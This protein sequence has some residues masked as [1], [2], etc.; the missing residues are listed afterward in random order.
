MLLLAQSAALK[1][2]EKDMATA[3]TIPLPWYD[4][5]LEL[6]SAPE[7]RLRMQ[8]LSDRVVLSRTRVS[9]LVDEMVAAGYVRREP[10]PSDGRAAFAVITDEG[11]AARRATA[12]LYL[13][14]IDRHFSRHLS[15]AEREALTTSLAKVVE[16]HRPE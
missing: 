8:E 5:L 14:A 1:A 3:G 2:I 13:E 12:P 6:R 7:M 15:R 10:D 4:V 16:A 9:R 11:R